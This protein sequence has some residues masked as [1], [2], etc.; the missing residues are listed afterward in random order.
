MKQLK[1]DGFLYEMKKNK[2]LYIMLIP[3]IL[4]FFLNCYMPMFGIYLAFTKFDFNGGIF[5]SPFVGMENFKYLFKSGSLLTITRNTILYN[6]VFIALGNFLQ[7]LVAIILAEIPGKVF[8]KTTQSLMFL[9]YFVSYVILGAFVYNILNYEKGF[10]NVTLQSLGMNPIDAFNMPGFWPYAMILFYIWKWL[11]YGT[12]IYLAAIMGISDDYYEASTIDG[13]SI[14]QQIWNIT[15][16]LLKP[17]FI[18]LLL[19]SLGNILR[20]QF[21]MFY[22]IVG[23]NGV[24]YP[25][26]DIIDTFV[27]RAI[28]INFDPGLGAAA[29][30]YQSVFG[31][32]LIIVVN[33]I[34]KRVDSDY[35]LF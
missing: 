17:T 15:L 24:L 23:S 5:G 26:T 14:L 13:A 16:P 27:Y 31:F 28:K 33:K 10:M 11:G 29:G 22:N 1:Q 18:I 2:V 20:G 7:I 32:V 25:T 9:P 4:F 35:A 12:V 34:V 3:A 8:K 6:I 19:L 30:L 21:D